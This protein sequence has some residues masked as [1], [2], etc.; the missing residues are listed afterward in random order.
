MYTSKCVRCG[1][2]V[3]LYCGHVKLGRKSIAAGF[4]NRCSKVKGF[5]GLYTGKMG[6]S[7]RANFK[8]P[9]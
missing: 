8:P 4:C 7:K 5:V 3:D 6:L 9:K 2:G 1:R